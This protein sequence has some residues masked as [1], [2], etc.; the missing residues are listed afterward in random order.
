MA[1]KFDRESHVPDDM[2]RFN[3]RRLM[4]QHLGG[5]DTSNQLELISRCPQ[6]EV[7][8]WELS[9]EPDSTSVFAQRAASGTWPNI[10]KLRLKM[11]VQD[12]EV[13]MILGGIKQL[14][15]L[16]LSRATFGPRE[17]SA[18]ERHFHSLVE[19]RLHECIGTPSSL[20]RNVLC[21]CPRLEFL[22]GQTILA[23]DVADGGPWVCLSL[24]ALRVQVQF[25]KSEHQDE[26]L[27]SSV[28]EHLSHLHK[29]QDLCV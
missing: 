12:E 19:L 26:S 17:S 9:Y 20:F 1:P 24:K 29:L 15:E 22:S 18:L 7:L 13:E 27:Q 23:K 14:T 11:L 8:N 28:F 10:T 2:T 4:L 3:I 5:M 21:S 25:T 6:L 16:K